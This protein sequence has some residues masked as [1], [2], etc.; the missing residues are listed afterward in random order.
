MK[1]NKNIDEW[2]RVIGMVGYF[3]LGFLALGVSDDLFGLWI[4]FGI[5]LII[6]FGWNDDTIKEKRKRS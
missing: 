2:K 4:V 5:F 1:I 3:G 6:A